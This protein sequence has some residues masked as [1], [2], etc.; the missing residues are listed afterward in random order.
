MLLKLKIRLNL[1]FLSFIIVLLFLIFTGCSR[2]KYP[3]SYG[4]YLC[5]NMNSI[6]KIEFNENMYIN[7]DFKGLSCTRNTSQ[8]S[9]WFYDP[10][11]VPTDLNFGRVT[12]D[13]DDVENI[14]FNTKPIDGKLG[15]FKVE[16]N[17]PIEEGVYSLYADNFISGSKNPDIQWAFL[18]ATKKRKSSYK[19]E[20]LG[21]WN[22]LGMPVKFLQNGDFVGENEKTGIY[23]FITSDSLLIEGTNG[24]TIKSKIYFI[25]DNLMC[26]GMWD[27]PGYE[28]SILLD[29]LK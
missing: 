27:E 18:I 22:M 17:Q 7:I 3:E 20:I 1:P 28:R 10:K 9:L 14:S 26:I 13:I 12:Y 23:K 8:I 24:E 6:E 15:L 4:V 16:I 19:K 25:S 29:R 5:E 21:K 2:N 11:I